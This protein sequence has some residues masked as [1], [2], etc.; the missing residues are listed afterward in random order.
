MPN[1]LCHLQSLQLAFNKY[2]KKQLYKLGVSDTAS[3][4]NSQSPGLC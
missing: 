4:L 3:W 2:T 1:K